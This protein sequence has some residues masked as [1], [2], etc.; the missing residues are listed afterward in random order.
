MQ[1][2]S[3]K[4]I[5]GW[6]MYDWA[7]SVYNLVITTTFFP[8]YF[9]T[10][11]HSDTTGDNVSF[12]GRTFVNSALYDYSM[13][14]AFMLAALLSP[15]LSSI[16]DTR[17]N[18]KR[19][20]M[21][22]TWLGG[23]SCCALFN[24][25][26]PDP[27]VEY[28]AIFFILATLGYCGGL[29]FYNSYLPEIA[30][31]ED[32]DRISARGYAM[33]YIGSVLLQLIGFALVVVKPFGIDGGMPVRITFLLTGLWW[34]GFAQITFMRLPASKA[35]VQQ[36]SASAL[37]EGFREL[38]KVYAQVKVM[39]VL[40][41][42]LRGFFFYSMGVQTVMMAA[43]IFGSQELGLPADKLIMAVVAI[44]VVAV[45][46]AW[47]IARLSGKFGNLPVLMVVVILWMVICLVG[48]RM[49]TAT[50]FYILAVVVGLVMGGVQ[51]LS[52]STYAKLMP[53]TDDTAS[54]FSYYDVVEKL[55]IAIGMITFGYIHELTGSMRNSVLA[56]IAFFFTGLIWLYAA[57]QKQKRL[58]TG[59]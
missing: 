53:E 40:K 26:G 22:F 51:S 34:I 54:F 14:A 48:Y 21:L 43:T 27:S 33:G 32:R 16:A 12:F 2:A 28:G 38:K 56:L 17:G 37:T 8:I 55:S 47:G 30:A 57:L 3:K 5:N 52:R 58:T 6:A 25:K 10:I 7:N 50:D 45:L 42:F 20:L 36:H 15:I 1:T 19:Y 4:V 39:P 49:Q 44:Q 13:A 11:T 24:F 29:V 41:R 46:G 23:L 31:I 35:T 18:K 59:S 9:T